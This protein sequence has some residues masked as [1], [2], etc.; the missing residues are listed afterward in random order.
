MLRY[1]ESPP[2]SIKLRAAALRPYRRL[3]FQS[4]GTASVVHK[5]EWLAGAHRIAIGDDVAVLGRCW[6]AAERSSWRQPGPALSIGDRVAIG[7]FCIIT[8]A[9]SVVLEEDVSVAS[10]SF[11]TD[12]SHTLAGEHA[13]KPHRPGLTAI[14][15]NPTMVAPIETAP[16]RIGRGTWIG[17]GAAVLHGSNIGIHCV[18]GAHSVVCGHIPD[19][20]VAAGAP[21]RVVGSTRD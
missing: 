7:A 18:I 9:E 11:I 10:H 1:L 6:L 17:N 21:A 16:V 12:V 4:F 2:V 3:R 5:P 20:S 13:V 14:N 15:P 19:H 8:A